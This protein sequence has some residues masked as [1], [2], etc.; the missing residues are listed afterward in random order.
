MLR[1]REWMGPLRDENEG[2][3]GSGETKQL[4][5]QLQEKDKENETLKNLL[6]Q[7]AGNQ[8]PPVQPSQTQNQQ[9]PPPID[10]KALETAFWKDPL[11]LTSTIA[12]IAAKQVGDAVYAS[13]Y[14]NNRDLARSKAREMNKEFFDK[15]VTAIEEKMTFVQP[16]F[17]TNPNMWINAMNLVKG[18]RFDELMTEGEKKLAEGTNRAPA[19]HKGPSEP[20]SKQAKPAPKAPLND[21]ERE[22]IRKFDLTEDEY[23]R[24][25][26]NFENQSEKGVSSWDEVVTFDSSKR[27]KAKS[28]A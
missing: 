11:T 20:S 21:Q 6:R 19:Y 10:K 4:Q 1:M 7:G 23:R 14:D 26:E 16:Q 9:Q 15:Y 5:A 2:P 24:G 13:T 27:K 18:E 17:H 28:A 3:E 25:K 12:Q 22:F 8:P